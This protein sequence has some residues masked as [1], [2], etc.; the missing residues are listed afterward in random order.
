MLEIVID[1]PPNIEEIRQAFTLHKGIVFTYGSRVY[2]PDAGFINPPLM[3][4]EMVHSK[5]QGDDPAGWWERYLRDVPW[6]ASQEVMAYRKQFK[7]IKKVTQDREL[8]MRWLIKVA[9]DLSGPMYGSP[10]QFQKAF[11]AIKHD[12][13]F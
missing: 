8:R 3:A 7:E 2:N 12:R 5:Q 9:K 11:Q 4:H 1:W 10:M 13:A 6:R